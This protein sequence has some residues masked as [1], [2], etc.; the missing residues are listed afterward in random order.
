[1]NKSRPSR[2][3]AAGEARAL[4]RRARSAAL[5]TALAGDGAWPYA[6]LVTV[7]CDGDGSPILLLSDLSDHTRNLAVDP[8]ASVLFEAA[9][10]RRNPQAG[11]RVTVL[12]R[13]LRSEDERHRR[14]FLARHPDARQYAGFGDF[15]VHLMVVERAHYVGGFAV[16]PWLAGRELLAAGRAAAS[17]AAIEEDVLAH[18]NSTHGDAVDLYANRLLRLKGRRW[19]LVGI[20]P[21]GVDLRLG[22]RF[23]RLDFGRPVRNRASCRAELVRLAR[24]ARDGEDGERGG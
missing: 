15:H 20:D 19:R 10:R 6:S 18:M 5:A 22:G 8:R 13:V 23:A 9:S 4:V 21:D 16:A 1:M 17:V 7:A 12:G 11:P 24:L 2:E 3:T 14:R